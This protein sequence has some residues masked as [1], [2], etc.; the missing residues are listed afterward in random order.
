MRL[1]AATPGDTALLAAIHSWSVARAPRLLMMLPAT[2]APGEVVV[3]RGEGLD[4]GDLRVHFGETTTWAMPLSAQSA[5]TVVPADAN[6]PAPLSVSRQGLR[7]NSL[8]WGGPPGDS[9]PRVLRI[10][11]EEGACGV[12]RDTPV[13]ALLSHSADRQSLDPHVLVVTDACSR[14]P[15]RVVLSPDGR[16]LVWQADRLLTAGMPHEVQCAGLRDLRGRE[17]TG[18]YSRFVPCDITW[19]E[20]A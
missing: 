5:V 2:A 13:V 4:A 6:G 19:S 1:K 17:I 9:P 15:G 10:D 8:A 12:F 7:S 18:R 11:P 16:V 14:V 3:L 20:L